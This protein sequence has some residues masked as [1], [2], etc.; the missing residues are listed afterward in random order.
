MI[1]PGFSQ[2]TSLTSEGSMTSP[3]VALLVLMSTS[4]LMAFFLSRCC[5]LELVRVTEAGDPRPGTPAAAAVEVI[6][7]SLTRLQTWL[8]SLDTLL[9][10]LSNNTGPVK[11]SFLCFY[12][13]VLGRAAAAA[14][15][16]REKKFKTR[17]QEVHF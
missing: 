11:N 7:N 10:M 6:I 1:R 5:T 3:F 17:R 12:F 15:C 4:S 16:Q 2:T 9:P 14:V 8:T 13:S